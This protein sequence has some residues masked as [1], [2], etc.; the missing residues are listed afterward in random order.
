[1][2]PQK[3]A[4]ATGVLFLITFVT[5]IPALLLYDPILKDNGFST[6]V[7]GAGADN[8]IGQAVSNVTK[9]FPD[10][11]RAAGT[12]VRV[13]RADAAKTELDGYVRM[14]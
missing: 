10:C 13:S 2:D 4:R 1:M 7:T 5:S 12:A 9:R 14:G 11:D 8:H 3:V 6:Y